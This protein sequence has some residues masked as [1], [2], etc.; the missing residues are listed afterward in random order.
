M[1]QIKL[2]TAQLAH[3]IAVLHLD[4]AATRQLVSATVDSNDLYD[5]NRWIYQSHRLL[6]LL[7]HTHH[8]EDA[9]EHSQSDPT[10]QS[11]DLPDCGHK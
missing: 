10:R 1:Y 3:L 5:I 9:H 11:T 7:T 2:N 4:I 8:E 6:H